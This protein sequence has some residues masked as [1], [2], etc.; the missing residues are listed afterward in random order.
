MV[1]AMGG[2][3][4]IAITTLGPPLSNVRAGNLTALAVI[5]ENRIGDY[6]E[7]PTIKQLGYPEAT[8]ESYEGYATSAKVPKERLEILRSAF[9]KAIKDSGV[10]KA[11]V[12][13]GQV[14]FFRNGPDYDA[15]LAANLEKLR[16]ISI[17]AGLV[18]D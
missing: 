9:E 1:A 12:G 15:F 5:A 14:P 13:S 7:V 4:D 10:Q 6:S 17:K 2:H 11:I 3:V 18:K 8:F 16:R